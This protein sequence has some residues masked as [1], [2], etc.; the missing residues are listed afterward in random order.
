MKCK[1]KVIIFWDAKVKFNFFYLHKGFLI[2]QLT[3]P[4]HALEKSIIGTKIESPH[5]N[6][7]N[8]YVL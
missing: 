2:E 5:L 3:F 1:I 4:S 6:F 8:Y 7:T